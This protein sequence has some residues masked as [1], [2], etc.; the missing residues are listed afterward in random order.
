MTL[1]LDKRSVFNRS[2]R[3]NPP[4]FRMSLPVKSIVSNWSCAARR[5]GRI[6]RRRVCIR[7]GDQRCACTRQF[8]SARAGAPPTRARQTFGKA[9]RRLPRRPWATRATRVRA[10]RAPHRAPWGQARARRK[11]AAQ[12]Q[13]LGWRSTGVERIRGAGAGSDPRQPAKQRRRRWL[14]AAGGPAGTARQRTSVGPMFSITAICCPRRSISLS[15]R[16]LVNCEASASMSTEMRGMTDVDAGP[17]CQ[18]LRTSA[19]EGAALEQLAR[20]L[21]NA[22][23]V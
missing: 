13:R 22:S 11:A 3:G 10:R 8:Y 5:T 2:K 14:A 7:G 21:S 15:L 9:P 17:G 6:Q 4:T 1:F 20:P 23:L 19:R 18:H 16:A 12:G